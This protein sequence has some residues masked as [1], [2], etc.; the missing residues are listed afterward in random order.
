MTYLTAKGVSLTLLFLASFAAADIF[1][2]PIVKRVSENPTR[3]AERYR[4]RGRGLA[5]SYD[6]YIPLANPSDIEYYGTF[7]MGSSK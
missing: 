7:Y 3:S 4:H 1:E 2:V 6:S 5:T